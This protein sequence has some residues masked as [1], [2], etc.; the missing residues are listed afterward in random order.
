MVKIMH[1]MPQT[2]KK[3]TL[4]WWLHVILVLQVDDPTWGHTA[5]G[6]SIHQ[7]IQHYTYKNLQHSDHV[8]HSQDHTALKLQ[9]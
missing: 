2:D 6:C 7:T 4:Y 9:N 8:A 1:D 5:S 3:K